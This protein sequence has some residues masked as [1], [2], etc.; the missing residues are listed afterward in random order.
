M[1]TT[2]QVRVPAGL[3]GATA[4]RSKSRNLASSSGDTFR[5]STAKQDRGNPTIQY[6]ALLLAA[7]AAVPCMITISLEL[8]AIQQP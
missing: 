5:P 7:A 8:S 6:F 3:R 4:G 2:A 1:Y